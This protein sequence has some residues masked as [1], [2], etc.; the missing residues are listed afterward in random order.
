MTHSSLLREVWGPAYEDVPL[1]RAH[2]ANLRRK[3]EPEPANPGTSPPIW[4]SGTAS[5][6]DQL[7][8][9]TRAAR[10]SVVSLRELHADPATLLECHSLGRNTGLRR[11][12]ARR[13]DTRRC[14]CVRA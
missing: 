12:G 13:R 6:P 9:S 1:L 4:A 3:V 2:I 14:G 5:P 10:R 11:A 8:G 7:Y